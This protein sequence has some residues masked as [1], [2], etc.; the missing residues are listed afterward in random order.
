MEELSDRDR[1]I[2]VVTFVIVG[3]ISLVLLLFEIVRKE[4]DIIAILTLA[5]M[6]TF[7]FAFIIHSRTETKMVKVAIIILLSLVFITII[8]VLFW[9]IFLVE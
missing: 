2:H 6:M 5:V 3:I 8:W 4:Y 7:T 9:L 1:K